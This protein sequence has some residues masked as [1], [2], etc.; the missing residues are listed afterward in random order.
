MVIVLA[1]LFA[2]I[3][4]PATVASAH[5]LVLDILIPILVATSGAY[6]SIRGWRV[7]L[8]LTED[9]VCVQNLIRSFRVPLTQVVRANAGSSGIW[10]FTRD[11]RMICASAVAKGRAD[12][13]TGRPAK[14]D[15]IAK[16]IVDAAAAT[17]LPVMAPAMPVP[18]TRRQL[19][20]RIIFGAVLM[21]SASV[22][23]DLAG[24]QSHWIGAAGRLLGL[25]GLAIAA[26]PA[27]ALYRDFR[28]RRR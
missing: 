11:G 16:L 15:D 23:S 10:I 2:G 14:Q 22:V 9:A 21:I 26:I 28:E 6:V 17:G 25:A 20:S 5:S 27:L 19:T 8:S 4:I 1:V 18:L 13:E 3:S 12:S 24:A 7:R